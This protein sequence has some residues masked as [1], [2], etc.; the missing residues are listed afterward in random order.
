ACTIAARSAEVEPLPLLPATSTAGTARSGEPRSASS[1]RMRSS[2]SRM[3]RPS[4]R[5]RIASALGPPPEA[6][7][8][9]SSTSRSMAIEVLQTASER[10]LELGAGNDEVEEAV[11]QEELAGLEPFGQALADRLLDH[12]RSGETDQGAR[13]GDVQVPEHREGGRDAAGRRIGQ[14]GDVRDPRFAQE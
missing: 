3:P 1:Q 2:P 7:T 6:F 13:L 12:P 5:A 4:R 9:V 10:P 8:R 11:L 14:H